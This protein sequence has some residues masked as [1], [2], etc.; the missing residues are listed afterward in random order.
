MIGLITFLA[1]LSMS[2][3]GNGYFAWSLGKGDPIACAFWLCVAVG[4]EGLKIVTPVYLSSLP[5]M[6]R[7]LACVL[8]PAAFGASVM[9]G[10]G[11][12]GMTRGEASRERT[13]L[14]DTWTA[15]KEALD[16]AK[17][18]LARLPQARASADQL[19][20]EHTKQRA[21][22]GPCTDAKAAKRDECVRLGE[23]SAELAKAKAHEAAT[24]RVDELR[25]QLEETPRPGVADVQSDQ[26]AGMLRAVGLNVSDATIRAG[27][28][29]LVVLIVELGGVL[30]L[31]FAIHP[32]RTRPHAPAEPVK[33]PDG[34]TVPEWCRDAYAALR[35][36][37]GP[38]LTVT[39]R[40]TV[41]AQR[42]LAAAAN[43]S[44]GTLAKW[45]ALLQQAGVASISTGAKG[46]RIEWR[47]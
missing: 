32:P 23:L 22:A 10:L 14:Q 8:W 13:A 3:G 11:F 2:L 30:A 25:T 24:S 38:G 4:V 15:R 5:A 18:S 21:S 39:E 19:S 34:P 9:L 42:S 47:V 16:A 44:T 40:E 37:T 28:S 20:A 6:L 45:L 46:T 1:L 29:V 43:S 17:A 41:G 35:H 26:T 31:W 27:F 36:I 12:A 7:V 33:G